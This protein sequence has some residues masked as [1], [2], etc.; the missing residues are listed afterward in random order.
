MKRKIPFSIGLFLVLLLFFFAPATA[1]ADEPFVVV[2]DPG[3]GG[4][5]LGA[6]HN[7][8]TEKE[9]TMIVANAMYEELNKYDGV[10]VYL[11]RE[12]DADLTLAERAEYAASVNADLLV[13]LHFNMSEYH[14]LFG[15]E[16]WISAFG[17][18]YQK[19]YAF[20]SAVLEQFSA[21]GSYSRGI[22]VRLNEEDLD[23]YGIIRESHARNVTTALIE[24]CFLDHEKDVDF[25]NSTEKL[26]QFGRMDATATAQYFGLS[27][28]ILGVDYGSYEKVSV[29]LPNGKIEPDIT[30]PDIC[31]IELVE[32]DKENR[33]LKISLSAEDYDTGMLY[34]SYSLDGGASFSALKEWPEADTF[35]FT[36]QVPNGTTP[37][38]VVNAY[39]KYDIYATSNDIIVDGFPLI[40]N[41]EEPESETETV[42]QA[43]AQAHS[44]EETVT[45]EVVKTWEEIPLDTDAVVAVEEDNRSFSVFLKISGICIG[46][47]FVLLAV[48]YSYLGKRKRKKKRKF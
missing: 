20:G 2:I 31:Y 43:V 23:Y 37:H 12:G 26:E 25:Y 21:I 11:T 45:Q 8:Y 40:S 27:S 38:I 16:V 24:H 5:N 42:V 33:Q 35:Q 3:H 36:V 44:E 1:Y 4:E 29:P 14:T 39:N 46:I 13:C 34:Y 32:A 30:P 7:G 22:K 47:L 48:G 10:E 18:D 9:I 6:Q 19:G 28:Q 17:E 41:V 15:S